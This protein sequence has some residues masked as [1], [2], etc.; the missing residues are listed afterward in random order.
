MILKNNEKPKILLACTFR[1]FDGGG[2]DDIQRIFLSSLKDQTFK[3]LELVITTFSEKKVKEVVESYRLNQKVFKGSVNRKK[4]YSQTQV[5]LNAISE[6]KKNPDVEYIIWTTVDIKF[7]SNFLEEIFRRDFIQNTCA[8]IHPTNKKGF[9]EKR[10]SEGFDFLLF[11]ARTLIKAEEDI[12]KYTIEG[13]G[14]IEHFLIAVATKYR[15]NLV[16]LYP[17]IKII[18][19]ENDRVQGGQTPSWILKSYWENRANL[20]RYLKDNALSLRFNNLFYCHNLFSPWKTFPSL[21]DLFERG[22]FELLLLKNRI[23]R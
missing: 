9:F 20:D 18:K 7:P 11:D 2:N 23:S 13:W 4:R 17:Q 12:R 5:L 1:E 8:T 16:N 10:L 3:E 6:A 19:M 21:G 14:I 22:K 15:M